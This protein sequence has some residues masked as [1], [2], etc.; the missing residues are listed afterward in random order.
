MKSN[1]FALSLL[2]LITLAACSPAPQTAAKDPVVLVQTLDQAAR[3]AG[4]A[5]ALLQATVRAHTETDVAFR[6]GGQVV[7]RLVE[8]GQAVSQGQ[9][10]AVLDLQDL[11]AQQQASTAAAQSARSELQ[12]AQ[13]EVARLE[14]LQGTG[15]SA[16]VDLERQRS[17]LQGLQDRQEQLEQQLRL[18]KQRRSYA[19]LKA[20]YDGVLTAWRAE[21]GTVVAE[22]QPVG[23]LARRGAW[24]VV[25]DVGEE[26]WVLIKTQ[27]A[28]RASVSVPAAGLVQVPVTLRDLSPLAQ[29]AA[30][31]G[32]VYRVRFSLP[33]SAVASSKA[34]PPI[35]LA[36][37]MHAE[38]SLAAAAPSAPPASS[39]EGGRVATGTHRLPASALLQ[40]GLKAQVWTVQN[41]EEGRGRLQALPVK[42]VGQG[43]TWVEVQGLVPGATVVTMG[44]QRL[45]EGQ[46]VRPVVQALSSM[47]DER[48]AGAR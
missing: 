19:E 25:A 1:L 21:P 48:S 45:R 23:S 35:T 34:S 36:L 27:R 3:G 14:R 4:A 42:V 40:D 47:A 29:G 8:V 28:L 11:Q 37:G 38:L 18:A 24:D 2:P 10:L 15:A 33:T 22:G 44:A 6:A 16:E 30:G 12:Q 32:R 13:R 41:V 26:H 17:R 5:Q 20:P 43:S 7:Q 46:T 39:G 9:V 31:G